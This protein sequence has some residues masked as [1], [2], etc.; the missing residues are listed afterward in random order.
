LPAVDT[1]DRQTVDA[2]SKRIVGND[3]VPTVKYSASDQINAQNESLA[4]VKK[5]QTASKELNR[6]EL[7]LVEIRK[8][9]VPSNAAEGIQILE[10]TLGE[11]LLVDSQYL[12]YRRISDQ[13]G[14]I[15]PLYSITAEIEKDVT[16]LVGIRK[17][18]EATIEKLREIIAQR[19]TA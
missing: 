14:K 16:R 10:D 12:E 8:T 9:V 7:Q 11:L 13:L 3:K 5:L 2:A 17:R 18:I 15:N 19:T 6:I 4:L 1:T